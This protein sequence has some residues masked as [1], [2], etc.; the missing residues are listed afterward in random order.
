MHFR[1]F[2]SSFSP[3]TAAAATTAA[4]AYSLSLLLITKVKSGFT[5][6]QR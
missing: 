3:C 2:S 5:P 4:A 6:L 1:T